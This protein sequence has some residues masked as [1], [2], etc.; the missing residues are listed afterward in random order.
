[1]TSGQADSGEAD[2]ALIG[3]IMRQVDS[4]VSMSLM[5]TGDPD[6][7]QIRRGGEGRE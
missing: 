6:A 1:M 5:G 7:E 3:S 2:Q 4:E